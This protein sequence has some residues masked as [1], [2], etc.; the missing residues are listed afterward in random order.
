MLRVSSAVRGM[1]TSDR[2][3]ITFHTPGPR[4]A[5]SAMAS[6]MAG[7]AIKPSMNRITTRSSRR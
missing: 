6:K 3:M 7:K 2:A 1:Y 5:I 4:A